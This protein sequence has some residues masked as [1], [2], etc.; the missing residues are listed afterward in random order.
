MKKRLYWQLPFLAL[1]IMGTVWI[2]SNQH[3][4]PYQHQSGMI[5]GTQYHVTY[6]SND[7]LQHEIENTLR[8]VDDEF[9]MF[10]KTSTVTLINQGKSPPA[11]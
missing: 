6:Q 5:F 1:L 4:T 11:Q 7:N 10:N 3:N 9:S 2:V 8:Q